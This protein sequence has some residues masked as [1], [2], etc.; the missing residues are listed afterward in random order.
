MCFHLDVCVVQLPTVRL[1]RAMPK[2]RNYTLRHFM[3]P[4]IAWLVFVLCV[5]VFLSET[6]YFTINF[7]WHEGICCTH[8]HPP[9]V[10]LIVYLNAEEATLD[11][12]W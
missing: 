11:V 5:Y 3:V 4:T 10:K 6:L 1:K 7:H 8:S 12:V 9:S 2:N